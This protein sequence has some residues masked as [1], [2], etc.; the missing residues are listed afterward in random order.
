MRTSSPGGIDSRYRLVRFAAESIEADYFWFVDDDDWVFPN[1]AE[2]LGLVVNTAP[3]NSIVFV[4]SQHFEEASLA[5]SP[6]ADAT[7]YRSKAARPFPA[8]DFLASLSGENHSPFCGVLLSRAALLN[9]PP[10]V[11]ER[12]TYFED[13][14]TILSALLQEDCFPVT[15]DKLFA[16]IS[17]RRSGN[18]VT[19]KDRRTWNESMSELA[20]HLVNSS[21]CS[22]LLSL[23]PQAWRHPPADGGDDL[24]VRGL[25]RHSKRF[26]GKAIRRVRAVTR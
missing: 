26:V 1:E 16:G 22:Q 5:R 8:E 24:T 18:S 7:S 2:R 3:E 6:N 11:Y 13:Y 25:A 10:A 9:V 14:M 23:P 15:V 4:G 12:V 21:D 19:E 17:L 20:S